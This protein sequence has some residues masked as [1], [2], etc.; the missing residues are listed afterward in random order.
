MS[1]KCLYIPREINKE[2]IFIWTRDTV[3]FLMLP[4]VFWVVL[5][6]L[7]GFMLSLVCSII[8]YQLIKQF[9]TDKPDG[10]MLHWVKY[11]VPKHYVS[12]IFSGNDSLETK[13]SLIFRG[14]PFPPTHIKH[15]AG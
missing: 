12:A 11:N 7:L 2:Y 15:I 13:E 6:S 1:N 3:F 10:Y 5:Q 8:M 14:D 9:G 4:W